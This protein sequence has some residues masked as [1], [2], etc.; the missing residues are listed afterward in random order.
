MLPLALIQGLQ[1]EHGVD[2]GGGYLELGSELA[3]CSST[4]KRESQEL[5]AVVLQQRADW[6]E[7]MRRSGVAAAQ[8][9]DD[10]IDNR[11]R[12]VATASR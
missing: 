8:F 9:G 6:V 1:V 4:C 12:S 7:P 5:V 11:Q 3:N 10:K 2:D